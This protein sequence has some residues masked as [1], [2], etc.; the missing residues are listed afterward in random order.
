MKKYLGRPKGKTTDY[1]HEFDYNYLLPNG[2]VTTVLLF[3][4][5]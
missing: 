2:E 4:K 5:G 3:I 1:H